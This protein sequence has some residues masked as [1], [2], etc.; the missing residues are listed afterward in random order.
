M[1]VLQYT[2]LQNE[3]WDNIAYKAYGNAGLSELLISA[4]PEVSISDVLPPG[5]I[6]NIPVQDQAVVL[7][8]AE[9]LPP[10]KVIL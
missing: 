7:T 8:D 10:W 5:T 6:L 4:N 9:L 1:A 2:T 3:R